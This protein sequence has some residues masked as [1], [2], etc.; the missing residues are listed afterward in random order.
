MH[1]IEPVDVDLWWREGTLL[2]LWDFTVDFAPGAGHFGQEGTYLYR[3]Q[4]LHGDRIVTTWFAD[5]FGRANGFGG[6]SAFTIDSNAQPF[7]WTDDGFSVPEVDDLVV[8]ELHVAEFNRSFDGVTAQL[9]YLA[10]LGVNTLELM[11]VTDVK[12]EVEWATPRSDILL[13]TSASAG[14]TRSS[15]WSTPRMPA[16]LP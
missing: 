12:E 2:D 13:P 9:D 6:F 16:A 8:Y 14:W 11:P 10:G 15:G 5:P 7:P 4:L 1:G 3:Y